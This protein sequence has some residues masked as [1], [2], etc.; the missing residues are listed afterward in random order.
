VGDIVNKLRGEWLISRAYNKLAISESSLFHALKCFEFA[1]DEHAGFQDFDYAYA[2]E[3]LS[4]SYA[5]IGDT[6]KAQSYYDKA[7]ELGKRISNEKDRDIFMGDL[8]SGNW[9]GFVP[10]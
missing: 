9:N 7:L 5:L 10:K 3:A 4:K 2:N 8:R 6:D 1:Q